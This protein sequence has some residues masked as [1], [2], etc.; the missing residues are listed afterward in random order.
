MTILLDRDALKSN[1]WRRHSIITPED[2]AYIPL[3]QQLP[4]SLQEIAADKYVVA[5]I[6]T[7]DCAVVHPVL[8][9]EPWLHIM[10]AFEAPHEKK[11]ANGRD[12][13]RIHFSLEKN[14]VSVFYETNAAC[15]CQI[16]RELIF[17]CEYNAT[18]VVPE[19]SKYDL[20]N[21]LSER[22]KL[23]TWP[24]NFNKALKPAEKKIKSI[25]RKHQE[26]ISGLYIKLN[27][28]DEIS[29]DGYVIAI[30][31]AIEKS[32]L[33]QLVINIRKNNAQLSKCTMDEAISQF[34][35]EIRNAFSPYIS[36]EE[37]VTVGN[38]LAI[39]VIEE[40][41]ITISQ[42]RQYSRFSPYS[43][44]EFSDNSILPIDMIPTRH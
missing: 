38:K 6:A 7:Y 20:M 39:A 11:F 2:E 10:L 5:I 3:L 29:P 16:D 4:I 22:F 37:D 19:A 1:G 34:I 42:L 25:W 26:Y 36:I 21:W 40:S 17:D 24:D 15:F 43:L 44:S 27:T 28:Y 9:V 12:P 18:M 32:K 41:S 13:R 35:N 14:G 33:R 30:I 31:V 8:E 23:T